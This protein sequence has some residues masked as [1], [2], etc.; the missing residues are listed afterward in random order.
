[1]NKYLIL[2]L[3]FFPSFNFS[4]DFC[5]PKSIIFPGTESHILFLRVQMT[6]FFLPVIKAQ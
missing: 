5:K 1:M 4:P 6:Y 2:E 3:P